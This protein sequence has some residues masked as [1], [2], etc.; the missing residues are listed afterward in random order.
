MVNGDGGV[1]GKQEWRG[2][3]GSGGGWQARRPPRYN[4]STIQGGKQAPPTE[5]PIK[6]SPPGPDPILL[7]PLLRATLPDVFL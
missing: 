1:E 7:T 3:L 4:T 2:G 5:A 6:K